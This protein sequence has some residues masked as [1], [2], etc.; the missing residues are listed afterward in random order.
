MQR[1]LII[2]VLTLTSAVVFAPAAIFAQ[3]NAKGMPT[4]GIAAA[5]A[6]PQTPLKRITKQGAI[7]SG[8]TPAPTGG[9]RMLPAQPGPMGANLSK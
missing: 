6:L 7:D 8:E 1:R 9:Q 3:Q 2:A 5:S 4:N